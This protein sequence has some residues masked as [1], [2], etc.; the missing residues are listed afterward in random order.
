MVA[1]AVTVL[2][3]LAISPGTLIVTV[4]T[5]TEGRAVATGTSHSKIDRPFSPNF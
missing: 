3:F 1:A 4:V 5:G 2:K